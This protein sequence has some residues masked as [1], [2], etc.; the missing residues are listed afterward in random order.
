MTSQ[1]E[2]KKEVKALRVLPACFLFLTHF[3]K[4][5]GALGP[6]IPITEGIGRKHCV[7]VPNPGEAD[8]SLSSPFPTGWLHSFPADFL[9]YM[10]LSD[11]HLPHMHKETT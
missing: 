5:R 1:S 2:K 11:S 10:V 8:M 9:F 7:R 6:K 4:K 3:L